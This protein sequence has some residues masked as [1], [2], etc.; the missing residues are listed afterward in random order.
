MDSRSK[1]DTGET[2]DLLRVVAEAGGELTSLQS[3][4]NTS[5]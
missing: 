5:R 4:I 3:I 2:V 1:G